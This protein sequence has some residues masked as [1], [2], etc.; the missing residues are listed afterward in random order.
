MKKALAILISIFLL[1]SFIAC[2]SET[3]EPPAVEEPPATEFDKADETLTSLDDLFA[4][5]KSP[6]APLLPEGVAESEEN[7]KRQL[8]RL[9]IENE[10]LKKSYCVRTGADGKPE[11]VP[12]RAKNM[13]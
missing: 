6:V 13:K 7:Y 2:S 5:D 12:L 1:F 3:P 10:R 8:I 9:T 11:Y 4:G